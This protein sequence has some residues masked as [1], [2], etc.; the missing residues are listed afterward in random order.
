MRFVVVVVVAA[1]SGRGATFPKDTYIK[2]AATDFV[3]AIARKDVAAIRTFFRMPF[4]YGG[5]WFADPECTKQFPVPKKIDDTNSEAFARCLATLPLR[6]SERVDP[7]FGFIVATYDPGIELEVGFGFTNGLARMRFIGYAGRRDLGDGIPTVDPAVLEPLRVAGDRTPALTPETTT[8]IEAESKELAV[9]G[10]YAWLKVCIDANGD[11]TSVHAREASSPL[12]RDTYA[13]AVQ[14]W[15]FQ[16]FKLGSQ[17]S[18]VCALERFVHLT[19]P[20][21]PTKQPSPVMLPLPNVGGDDDGVLHVSS[22]AVKRISGD[23]LIAPAD[24]DQIE[25]QMLGI[26]EV[27]A[28][29]AVCFDEQ[30]VVYRVVPIEPSGLASYDARLRSVIGTWRYR[31]LSIGGKPLKVCTGVTFIY[32]QRGGA[33]HNMG[34]VRL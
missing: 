9:K 29:F 3:D 21:E 14:S 10:A 32:S 17:L 8:A 24:S 5:M 25:I 4:L 13:A 23:K 28:H 2:R 22:N 16:P 12:A 15:K 20:A 33:G 27:R 30:G 18:P 11:V 19:A 7:I 6:Q 26:D 1:C 34:R 31:P